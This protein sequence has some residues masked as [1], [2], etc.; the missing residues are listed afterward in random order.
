MKATLKNYRQSPRK[1][2]L[3]ANLV[4]GKSVNQ[5][6]SELKYTPKRAS[7]SI[8]KL[9]ESA[10]AN[11][12]ANGP[13]DKDSL[14]IKDIQINEGRTLYRILPMS[15]GRAFRIRKRTSHVNIELGEREGKKTEKKQEEAPTT[16]TKTKVT[17]KKEAAPKKKASPKNK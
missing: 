3:V 9:I 16:K 12:T 15:R 4:R 6:L 8:T 14:F 1:V 11:A 5:A 13:K 2:R 7:H 17:A 10:V